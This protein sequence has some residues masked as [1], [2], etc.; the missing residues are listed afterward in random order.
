M[1]SKQARGIKKTSSNRP[2]E[3]HEKANF[4]STLNNNS[5]N[6]KQIVSNNE[7]MKTK[8][9]GTDDKLHA[10]ASGKLWNANIG[11]FH[12]QGPPTLHL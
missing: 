3:L 10:N 11:V 2:A 5:K 9:I 4:Y 12:V 6:D 8:H 1:K 7:M